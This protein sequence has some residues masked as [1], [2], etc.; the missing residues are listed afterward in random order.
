MNG[1]SKGW[2]CCL[3]PGWAR[4]GPGREQPARP[5]HRRPRSRHRRAM[6][7][8]LSDPDPIV[9]SCCLSVLTHLVLGGRLKAKGSVAKVARLMADSDAGGWPAA[10]RRAAVAD[11][12]APPGSRAPADADG[13]RRGG[14]PSG[15]QRGCPWELEPHPPTAARPRS[16]RRA[17]PAV[18]LSAGK[19]RHRL[20]ARLGVCGGGRVG[21]QPGLQPAARHAQRAVPRAGACVLGCEPGHYEH[22]LTRRPVNTP[23]LCA[24]LGCTWPA[25][26]CPC[27]CY[28][29]VCT[30]SCGGRKSPPSRRRANPSKGPV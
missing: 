22:E 9:R 23:L 6:Y 29:C 15:Q 27:A 25:E 12:L 16:H 8:P 10:A 24:V 17:R 5:Q 14:V 13:Q 3:G 30:K 21:G 2:G 1:F 18:L 28:A 26:P 20:G 4:A 19:E 11:P 7:E